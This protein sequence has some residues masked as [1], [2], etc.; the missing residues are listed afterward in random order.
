M[1][2]LDNSLTLTKTSSCSVNLTL[3]MVLLGNIIEL[4]MFGMQVIEY[5]S[6]KSIVANL[7]AEKPPKEVTAEVQKVLS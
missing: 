2:L 7:H 6:K 1:G 4:F 3:L 5:Y